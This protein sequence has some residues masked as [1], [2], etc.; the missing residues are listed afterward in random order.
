MVAMTM[1]LEGFSEAKDNLL[2]AKHR[3]SHARTTSVEISNIKQVMETEVISQEEWKN[4]IEE[5]LRIKWGQLYA[6]K[7]YFNQSSNSIN[8]HFYLKALSILSSCYPIDVWRCNHSVGLGILYNTREH[9]NEV[10]INSMYVLQYQVD[11]ILST[12]FV[13]TMILNRLNLIAHNIMGEI[14]SMPAY[15][16]W[17][18]GHAPT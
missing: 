13:P 1:M 3:I 9:D 18:D 5:L 6:W 11:Y 12:V 15:E 16:V 10:P 7:L 4:K 8:I 17:Q 2:V 14:L